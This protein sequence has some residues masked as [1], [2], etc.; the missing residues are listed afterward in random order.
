[1]GIGQYFEIFILAEFHLLC[2]KW[3]IIYKKKNSKI[4][5]ESE[6]IVTFLSMHKV[7]MRLICIHATFY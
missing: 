1:M 7:G 5:Y 4:P 2:S 3:L 6:E